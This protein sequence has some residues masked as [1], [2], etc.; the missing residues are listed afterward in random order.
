MMCLIIISSRMGLLLLY[1][2]YLREL[3]N[4]SF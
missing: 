4:M 3:F 2:G 1:G